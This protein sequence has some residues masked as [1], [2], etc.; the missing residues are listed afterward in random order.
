[1][2]SAVHKAHLGVG[3]VLCN[4]I[5]FTCFCSLLKLKQQIKAVTLTRKRIYMHGCYLSGLVER[6]LGF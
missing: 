2:L 5:N 1:M 6:I 3:L 4:P